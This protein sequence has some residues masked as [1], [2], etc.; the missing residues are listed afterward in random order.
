[1]EF[2]TELFSQRPPSVCLVCFYGQEIQVGRE[3][4]GQPA[5]MQLSRGPVLHSW[6]SVLMHTQKEKTEIFIYLF[7]FTDLKGNIPGEM[8]D[9]K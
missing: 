8:A 4:G 6:S 3:T 7:V 5:Q 9:S 2:C 1:M